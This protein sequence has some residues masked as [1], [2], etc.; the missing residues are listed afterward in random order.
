M[1]IPGRRLLTV[2][3]CIAIGAAVAPAASGQVITRSGKQPPAQDP[4]LPER[5]LQEA[6]NESVAHTRL[7]V[8]VTSGTR[9]KE[10]ANHAAWNNPA[11]QEWVKWHAVLVHVTDRDTIN[12]LKSAGMVVGLVDQPLLFKA[13]KQERIFGSVVRED[14]GIGGERLRDPPPASKEAKARAAAGGPDTSI[15]LLMRLEWTRRS[16]RAADAAWWTAHEQANPRPDAPNVPYASAAAPDKLDKSWGDPE[17]SAWTKPDPVAPQGALTVAQDGAAEGDAAAQAVEVFTWLWE[18]GPE[19]VP[20]FASPALSTV[21]RR[22]HLLAEQHPPAAQRAR[23]MH[24]A[25]SALLPYM[26]LPRLFEWLMLARIAEEH[27][28]ALDFLDAALDDADARSMMPAGDRLAIE[29]MLPWVNWADPATLPLAGGKAL[30]PL[31]HLQERLGRRKPPKVSQEEWDRALEFARWLIRVEGPRVYAALLAAGEDQDAAAA[32]KL[33]QEVVGAGDSAEWL[34]TA[35]LC[36]GQAKPEHLAMLEKAPGPWA[37]RL[38][39]L[40]KAEFA[41]QSD[42]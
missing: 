24:D 12:L 15:R 20:S 35:A 29:M 6:L 37:R 27:V 22:W 14:G 38:E 41:K 4:N 2:V 13:G 7:L 9:E 16:F 39:E 3:V 10:K 1:R 18:R 23:V 8:V 17:N 36:E 32:A 33:V 5:P 30:S 42:R 25:E 19:I 11:L 26:D 40:L 31:K 34:V 28:A 21:A